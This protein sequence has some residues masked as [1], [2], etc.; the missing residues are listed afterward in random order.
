MKK[1]KEKEGVYS[2]K[3]QIWPDAGLNQGGED[4]F[5]AGVVYPANS[6]ENITVYITSMKND[7]PICFCFRL[8]KEQT[9]KISFLKFAEIDDE[10]TIGDYNLSEEN[11][12]IY[13]PD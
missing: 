1:D 4:L 13:L 3:L 8:D 12:G 2:M 7:T 9:D 6:E 10:K 11:A 5:V